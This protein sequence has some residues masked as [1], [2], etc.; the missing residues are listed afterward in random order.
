M[1]LLPLLTALFFTSTI[2]A[3]QLTKTQARKDLEFLIENIKRYNPALSMYHPEFDELAQSVVAEIEADPP[4]LFEHYRNSCRIAAFAGEGHFSVNDWESPIQK[5]LLDNSFTYLPLRVKLVADKLY[6]WKDVSNEQVVPTGSQLLAINGLETDQILNQLL[7]VMPSD[8]VI[9][10]Y[11]IRKIEDIFVWLYYLHIERPEAF[12]L[13]FLEPAGTEKTVTVQ[14]LNRGDQSA[15]YQQ[16]H[17][18]KKETS[19]SAPEGF[20]QLSYTDQYALLRLPSF[21]FRRVNK[22]EVK[23]KKMYEVLFTELKNKQVQNLVVDLRNN[24]GGR[25]EFADDMVPFI[26]KSDNGDPYLKKTISWEGKE[27]TYKLPKASKLLF[28]GNIYVLINGKTFFRWPFS[29][30]FLKGIRQSQRHR[31]RIW[32]PI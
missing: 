1:K 3:Q 8:G 5:G 29:S 30:S 10:S 26:L 12:E 15:N 2:H 14:A 28:S 21:D 27:R 18:T 6:V 20:Y 9:E 4:S 24:T 11:A 16:Y 22:Y 31:N 25:N 7:A 32:N 13:R 17:P 19:P 23:S